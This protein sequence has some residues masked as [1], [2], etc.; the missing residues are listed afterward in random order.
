M[1]ESDRC[2]GVVRG[3]AWSQ[4]EFPDSAFGAD[5]GQLGVLPG[6]ATVRRQRSSRMWTRATAD[7]ARVEIAPTTSTKGKAYVA[8]ERSDHSRF[9][10]SLSKRLR[11]ASFSGS[12]SQ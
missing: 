2:R 3:R 6:A 5:L 1:E 9:A 7:A 12:G 8:N 11:S 4:A 10:S